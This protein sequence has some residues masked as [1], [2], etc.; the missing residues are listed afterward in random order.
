MDGPLVKGG[1]EMQIKVVKAPR[2]L[3][4]L[5]KRVFRVR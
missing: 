2:F 4:A 3:A 5:L 1:V